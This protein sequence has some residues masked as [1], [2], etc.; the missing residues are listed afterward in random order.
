MLFFSKNFETKETINYIISIII[1]LTFY[2]IF[3]VKTY[4]FEELEY[5][6]MMKYDS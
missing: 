6:I 2:F 4:Y 1:L 3:F 5:E